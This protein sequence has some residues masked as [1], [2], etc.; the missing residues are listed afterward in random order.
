LVSLSH[1]LATAAWHCRLVQQIESERPENDEAWVE[2]VCRTV[3]YDIIYFLPSSIYVAVIAL[4]FLRLK[5]LGFSSLPSICFLFSGVFG[6]GPGHAM[7]WSNKPAGRVE[8][9]NSIYLLPRPLVVRPIFALIHAFR[10]TSSLVGRKQKYPGFFL[11]FSEST[12][13]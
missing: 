4:A 9:R 5:Q 11:P 12:P 13:D 1:F 10:Y 6:P 8:Y 7:P 2:G 3:G